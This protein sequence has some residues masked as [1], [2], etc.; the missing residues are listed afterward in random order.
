[1]NSLGIPKRA[2]IAF[3]LVITAAAVFVFPKVAS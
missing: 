2:K 3:N 1:M